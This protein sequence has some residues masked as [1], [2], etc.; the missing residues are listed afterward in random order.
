MGTKVSSKT[1]QQQKKNIPFLQQFIMRIFKY[2]AKLKE[3]YRKH[4]HTHHLDSTMDVL[5]YL[6]YHIPARLL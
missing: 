5:L 2:T 4:P 6:L 1:K 3:L